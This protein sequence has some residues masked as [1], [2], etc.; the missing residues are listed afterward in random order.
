MRESQKPSSSS[1]LTCASIMF[2]PRRRM[3]PTPWASSWLPGP[4]VPGTE[5]VAMIGAEMNAPGWMPASAVTRRIS[6]SA[7]IPAVARGEW[8]VFWMPMPTL[9]SPMM[10]A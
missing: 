6:S 2:A 4:T 5:S 3:V 7:K 8:R 9:T 10:V 1:E